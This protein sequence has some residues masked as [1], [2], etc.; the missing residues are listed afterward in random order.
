V[1]SNHQIVTATCVARDLEIFGE[2]QSSQNMEEEKKHVELT[3][4]EKF[5]LV[6]SVGEECATEA[7]LKN[8]L[9]KKPNFILYDGC[10][11]HRV[12]VP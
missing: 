12:I 8:L 9:A 10:V 11:V 4:E 1:I 6:R 7:E 5:E 2:H 3:T